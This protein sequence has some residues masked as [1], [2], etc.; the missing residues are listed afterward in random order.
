MGSNASILS[1]SSLKLLLS[2]A[3]FFFLLSVTSKWAM[4]PASVNV[5]IQA[6]VGVR[7]CPEEQV[8]YTAIDIKR[9]C[10]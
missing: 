5:S 1:T 3:P 2:T 8:A 4:S 10:N 7:H 6:R 9:R